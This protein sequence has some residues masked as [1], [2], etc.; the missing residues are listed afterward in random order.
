MGAG[1][2]EGRERTAVSLPLV[3]G[4]GGKKKRDAI[5]ETEP[6]LKGD[7]KLKS[8]VE[9]NLDSPSCPIIT[10]PSRLTLLSEM[11]PL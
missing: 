2:F 9:L 6:R 11:Y 1:S 10:T 5:W 3:L 4:E 8:Q 7:F